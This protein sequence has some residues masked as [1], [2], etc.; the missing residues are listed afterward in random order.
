MKKQYFYSGVIYEK[1]GQKSFFH[2]LVTV[3][4]SREDANDVYEGIIKNLSVKNSVDT[5]KIF[6]QQLNNI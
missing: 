1:D 3:E 6:L 4:N 5:N 2:G